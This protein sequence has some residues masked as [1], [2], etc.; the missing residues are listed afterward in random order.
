MERDFEDWKVEAEAFH[1]PFVDISV[2]RRLDAA[3]NP[4]TSIIRLHQR[5]NQGMG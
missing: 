4:P 2:D 5:R 1:D 3:A